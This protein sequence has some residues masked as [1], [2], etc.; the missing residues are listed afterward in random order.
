MALATVLGACQPVPQPF[1]D[2]SGASNPLLQV[3]E[4]HGLFVGSLDGIPGEYSDRLRRRL[5]EALQ[6]E[7]VLASVRSGNGR[8]YWLTGS[9]R[10]TVSGGR[11]D[12]RLQAPGGSVVA[13]F[14]GVGPEASASTSFAREVAVALRRSLPEEEL[15]AGGTVAEVE[16]PA[17]ALADVEGAPGDGSVALTRALRA[18][19]AMR[20]IRVATGEETDLTV[21]G[22]V[23]VS[24]AR[25][26]VERV[27]L[28]WSVLGPEGE[29]LGTVEQSNEIAAGSLNGR[30]GSV[31]EAAAQGAADGIVGVLDGLHSRSVGGG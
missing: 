12:W 13:L 15:S 25:P 17:M 26:G 1:A 31:A 7:G 23:D 22:E 4:T 20:G 18:A 8:S 14:D 30:W 19:L 3:P 9:V 10:C 21:R 16:G 29:V 24:P 5:A 27:D 6:E 11:L 28:L 2:E